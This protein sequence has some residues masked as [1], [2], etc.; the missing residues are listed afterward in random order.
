MDE[1]A[2]FRPLLLRAAGI[3]KR[4]GALV[5]LDGVDFDVPRH[6]LV[7]LIGPNGAGKTVFFDILTGITGRPSGA[8]WFNGRDLA[9]LTPAQRAGLGIARTFQNIR[10][11]AK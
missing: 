7:S 6:T 11:F 4:F 2:P 1:T 8:I 9:G 10:L 3:T 5:A